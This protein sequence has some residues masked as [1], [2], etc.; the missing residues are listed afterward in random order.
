MVACLIVVLVFLFVFSQI[1]L[2]Y[3][4]KEKE[5][6]WRRVGEVQSQMDSL[7]QELE[8]CR[9]IKTDSTLH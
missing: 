8:L 3:S 9:A 2:E 1:Q 6:G 7:E 5:I 4:A